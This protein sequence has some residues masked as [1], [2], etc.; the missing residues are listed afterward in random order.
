MTQTWVKMGTAHQEAH[1]RLTDLR[2][3]SL[4]WGGVKFPMGMSNSTVYKRGRETF[5]ISYEQNTLKIVC[6][7]N[8]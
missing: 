3:Q 5:K 8:L 7:P 2:A 1:R 4:G 6:F